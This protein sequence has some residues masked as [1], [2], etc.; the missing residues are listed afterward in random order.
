MAGIGIVERGNCL[1]TQ[2]A[3]R[4]IEGNGHFVIYN[5]RADRALNEPGIEIF[6]VVKL[7]WDV[8]CLL[9]AGKR[10]I[11]I[12][13]QHNPSYDLP[14]YIFVS[15]DALYLLEAAIQKLLSGM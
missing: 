15:S 3:V 4:N 7:L 6:V 9:R 10:V 2:A 5:T 12:D 1:E 14:G 8:G 13:S 11:Y